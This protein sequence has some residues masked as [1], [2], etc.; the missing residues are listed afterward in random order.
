MINIEKSWSW[1]AYILNWEVLLWN[2][3]SATEFLYWFSI[4]Q[5]EEKEN[6]LGIINTEWKIIIDKCDS[7]ERELDC[8]Y[9][10]FTKL[11]KLFPD[12]FEY[13]EYP[14][15]IYT[16]LY[17]VWLGN[18][19]KILINNC[20]TDIKVLE[21]EKM[22]VVSDM[23][24]N[25]RLYDIK[26]NPI[27]EYIWD[28]FE[29]SFLEG[30]I[31]VQSENYIGWVDTKWNYYPAPKWLDYVFNFHNWLAIWEKLDEYYVLIDKETKSICSEK[32]KDISFSSYLDWLIFAYDDKDIIFMNNKLD[33]LFKTEKSKYSL[34]DMQ[35]GIYLK[36]KDWNIY[37]VDEKNDFKII[38]TSKNLDWLTTF[39]YIP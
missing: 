3:V 14:P 37:K 24:N 34:Y 35:D 2:L 20:F 11:A 19:D 29:W 16:N 18:K 36:D 23:N 38:P 12:Y 39:Q 6:N 10:S 9:F 1:Y 21:K 13:S 32:F 8:E 28:Y 15:F 5:T 26:G 4:F 27:F 25:Y 31:A 30:Y 33:I 22:V 17:Y 7:I